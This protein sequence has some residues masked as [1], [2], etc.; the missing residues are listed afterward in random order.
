MTDRDKDFFGQNR[1][2]AEESYS[3]SKKTIK[4]LGGTVTE[5]DAELARNI[6]HDDLG[7]FAKS[8]PSVYSLDEETRDRLIA[9]ARQDA[10]HAVLFAGRISTEVKSLKRQNKFLMV[11]IGIVIILLLK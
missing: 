7:Y 3:I 8:W 5:L 4:E 9:H 1:L 6:L 2:T 11:L 10:A